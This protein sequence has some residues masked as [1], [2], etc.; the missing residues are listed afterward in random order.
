M[1]YVAIKGGG[2]AIAESAQV[3][4]FFR[5]EQGEDGSPLTLDDIKHQLRFIH[6]RILSEGGLYHP[7]LAALAL[8]QNIGDPLEASFMLRATGRQNLG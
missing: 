1:A 2:Q 4:E 3:M 6:S 5:T 8:K 7:D